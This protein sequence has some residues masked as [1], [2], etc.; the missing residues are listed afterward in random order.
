MY[1]SVEEL[2]STTFGG[3]RFSRKQIVKIQST[4]C[5]FTKLSRRE[6]ANTICEHLG[7]LTPSGTNRSQA[8]LNALE[9]M[10]S[11][12]LF[13]LPAKMEST[14]KR[15]RKPITHTKRTHEQPTINDKLESLLPIQ[16]IP[17]VEPD[18]RK[19]WNEYIDRY[20]Y[21][22]YKQPIG[23]HLRYFVV[24]NKGRK[25]GGMLFS[26]ASKKLPDR[27][28]WI[29][30]DDKARQKRLNLVVNNNRYLI[31]PWVEV[32]YLASKTISLASQQ[33]ADDW[34]IHHGY[35]PLLIET[36]VD[37]TKYRGTCYQ[38]ANWINVGETAGVHT[39]KNGDR[40]TIKA[41]Y[42]YPLA[43]NCKSKLIN[44]EKEKAKRKPTNLKP[45]SYEDGAP[46][47]N[48]W[49]QIITTIGEVCD[50]FDLKWR[51]RK[52]I[53]NTLLLV[54]FVFRL[55][56][57]KNKQ[58]YKITINE[59]WDQCKLLGLNLPQHTPVAPSAFCTARAK[60]DENIF[61]YLNAKI[62]ES[63]KGLGDDKKWHGH[64]VF[65]VDGTKINLPRQ[66]LQCGYKLPH[67]KS[68]YP[69]GLVSCLY[70]LRSRVPVDFD[71]K[72]DTG[73]R[74]FALDHLNKLTKGDVV[75]YD[76]GY[77][78]Y[79]MLYWHAKK[80]I[81]PVFRM[82]YQT[83]PA[84]T[85][86]IDSEKT[87]EIV[88]IQLTRERFTKIRRKDPLI[89][90]QSLKIRLIKYRIGDELYT[91]GTTLYD[92]KYSDID[93]F[94]KLYHERWDI[95]ELYKISKVLIEVQDFHAQTER[96][97][98]QEL[99]AHFVMITLSRIFSN[100]IE[101]D[102]QKAA[103]DESEHNIRVN[104]KNCLITVSRNLEILFIQQNRMLKKCISNMVNSI[105]SCRQ[106]VRPNRSYK[107]LSKK[108]YGKWQ[109]SK[110]LARRE[111][112]QA[113]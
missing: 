12:N 113:T 58:G 88:D 21:L 70:Q 7:W 22:G 60:L 67:D 86:F 87:D 39:D 13:E 108:P 63:Y 52:R 57:S 48:C 16:L 75:V 97:I 64:R 109:A 61:K 43:K 105:R 42:L 74:T 71:L 98:K 11:A 9:Q 44:G 56:F 23:S 51:K 5:N 93:E 96:G 45:I 38:A 95:E 2:R 33:L 46:F 55:V 85:Q 18:D 107:R 73:E 102:F 1:L 112:V 10:E 32:K 106:K 66:L 72:P 94:S 36:F 78:S 91:L 90:T 3:R 37:T 62:L 89:D 49:R 8:C 83:Y 27:D 15:N 41:I 59:L 54:L 110:K 53:V 68:H 84:I 92:K 19:L 25:L 76:R 111:V 103:H 6:L 34:S 77:F 99:Y 81:H 65:A 82:P 79:A 17:A 35:R 104:M 20:H 29:G 28:Y 80:G 30:W 14:V 40:K 100:H 26:F 4:V 47:V 50:E 31:F 69:F 24:D 101:D